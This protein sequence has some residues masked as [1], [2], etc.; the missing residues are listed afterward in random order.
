MNW[1]LTR[2]ADDLAWLT[3]ATPGAGLNTLSKE[4]MAELSILVDALEASPPK[5]LVIRSGK[6]NGFIAG[7]NIEEFT[8]LKTPSRRG[9]WWPV[10]GTSLTESLPCDSRPLHSFKAS[11]LVVVL[12]SLWP[13]ATE[14]Q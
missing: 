4:A 2:D 5:A 11:A 14:W 3:I 10:A 6:A 9:S 13:A 1:T 8:T 12:N 7:A